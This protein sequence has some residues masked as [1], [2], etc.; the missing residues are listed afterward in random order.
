MKCDIQELI[1]L[2]DELVV[3]FDK[4]GVILMANAKM[5]E[6]L[7]CSREDLVGRNV[8]WLRSMNYVTGTLIIED[9]IRERK[10]CFKN[11]V[12][13]NGMIVSYT[14][15]PLYDDE[16]E[17]TGGVLTGRDMSYLLKLY[18]TQLQEQAQEVKEEDL[19]GE[20]LAMSR[21]KRLIAKAALTDAP[22]FICGESG[23]GKE[24]VAQSI[25]RN[26]RRSNMPMI[27]VNCGAIPKE[28]I[29]S[30]LFGYEEGAFTGAK[31]GGK[32]GLLEAANGGTVFLD[33][34]GTLPKHLQTRLL[35]VLQEN[36]VT[37]IGGVREI[38]LD[39]RYI[40]AT[41]LEIDSIRNEDVFRQDLYYRLSVIP[42][43]MPPLRNRSG[44]CILL[45][46]YFLESFNRKYIKNVRFSDEVKD[47]I[48]R[49]SWPGNVRELRNI[50][51]RL[52]IISDSDQ[53]SLKDYQMTR[54]LDGADTGKD[55]IDYKYHG[56]I[57][58][59]EAYKKV[60]RMLI[61]R[62]VRRAGSVKLAAKMLG[63]NRSTLYRK[64][65]AAGMDMDGG[66]TEALSQI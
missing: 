66:I 19:I 17:F 11:V 3:L 1:D 13:S 44:D 9:L 15:N 58:L 46:L 43:Q 57:P 52:V 25:Y 63:V 60:D 2:M 61:P 65:Q 21:V 45:A 62:A 39:I 20:S 55:L 4:D 35:R 54:F 40:C 51:E 31:K 6:W 14:A 7:P 36:K 24:L 16:G 50:I 47:A 22:V 29:E 64:A 30:E 53:I 32:Q 33:E 18:N 37:R 49:D 8:S 48:R 23:T 38:D 28:L 56:V 5:D 41:N 10:P 12:Y 34:I 27:A 59:E 42:I 26:S